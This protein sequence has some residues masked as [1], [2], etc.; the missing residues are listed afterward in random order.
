M[1]EKTKV[2]NPAVKPTGGRSKIEKAKAVTK[3]SASSISAPILKRK[4]VELSGNTPKLEKSNFNFEDFSKLSFDEQT[5]MFNAIKEVFADLRESI[6]YIDQDTY[7]MAYY[8]LLTEVFEMAVEKNVAAMDYLC[9]LY[10]RGAEGYLPINLTLAHKWGM[11]AISC[12]SKLSIDRL[13]LFLDPVFEFV[14][15]EDLVPEMMARNELDDGEGIFFVAET[16]A[17]LYL[18][19]MKIDLLTM[20]R[21]DPL[22][23]DSDFKRFLNE[24]NKVRSEVLPDMVKYLI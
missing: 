11:L 15:Q 16:F 2:P 10:K 3:V 7:N 12:G 21:E 22:Q 6:N 9:Y 19:R 24:A 18:Q 23:L 8:T 4:R 17:G 13:R 14:V 20:A 1:A 5:V